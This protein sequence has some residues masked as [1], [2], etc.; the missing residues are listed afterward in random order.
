MQSTSDVQLLRAY[1]AEGSEA[2]FAE[3]VRRHADLVYSAALRQVDSPDLARD[4]TQAVFT[5]LGRKAAPLAA[6]LP[7]EATL[8]GWLHRGARYE[9][10]SLRR[11]EHRRRQRE[12]HAMAHLDDTSDPP[13]DWDALRPC[14]DEALDELEPADRDALLLRYFENRDLRTVGAALGVSDDAAQKRVARAV[15]KLRSLLARRGVKTSAAGLAAVIS[16]QAVQAAPTALTTALLSLSAAGVATTATST[17]TVA[18]LAMTTT[19]KLLVGTVLAA[20]LGTG[21]HEA[22]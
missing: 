4:V 19:Q 17:T 7:E 15:D 22:R 16:A 13:V 21:V 11:D 10:L 3:L 5:D 6:S 2:A 20:A 8:I 18:T 12:L 9:A 1:A 14:L